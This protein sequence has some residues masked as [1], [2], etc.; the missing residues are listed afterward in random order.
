MKSLHDVKE[1]LLV[2]HNIVTESTK[3]EE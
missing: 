2:P 1:F 3:P